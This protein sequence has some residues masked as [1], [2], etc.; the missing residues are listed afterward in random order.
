MRY[1]SKKWSNSVGGYKGQYGLHHWFRPQ[2]FGG[3]NTGWN[4]VPISKG[5]NNEM[6]N[7]GLLFN[8]FKYT[9]IAT[10]VSNLWVMISPIWKLNGC[11]CTN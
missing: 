9:F 3:K 8:A 4:L 6:S 2:S 1:R 11:T 10:Y 5:F 7:Q